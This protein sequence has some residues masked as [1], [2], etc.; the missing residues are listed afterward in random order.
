MTAGPMIPTIRVTVKTVPHP[1]P[2]RLIDVWAKL[3][4]KEIQSQESAER[5][6]VTTA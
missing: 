1:E 2:E 5:K 4:L 6:E 3:V